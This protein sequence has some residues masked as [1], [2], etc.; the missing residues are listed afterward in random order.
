MII[1]LVLHRNAPL[2]EPFRASVVVS[3]AE[4][5]RYHRALAVL[6]GSCLMRAPLLGAKAPEITSR[7]KAN[8]P[9]RTK[10]APTGVRGLR[11]SKPGSSHRV[12]SYPLRLPCGRVLSGSRAA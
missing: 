12:W 2:R 6:S 11:A 3:Q 8:T 1:L 7:R 9:P 10:I 4:I 5:G